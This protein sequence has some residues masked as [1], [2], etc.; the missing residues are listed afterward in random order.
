METF[1]DSEETGQDKQFYYVVRGKNLDGRKF[2]PS[3]WADRLVG[4]VAIFAREDT[5]ASKEITNCICVI[6]RDGIKGIVLDPRLKVI[7]R[8]MYEFV[9]RF[10]VDNQL[11]VVKIDSGKWN[12][13]RR[14][15]TEMPQRTFS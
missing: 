9:R 5:N 4:A 8:R 7:E 12:R 2:R 11:E 10:A 13:R 6:N 1:D 14:R 3:D 15:V